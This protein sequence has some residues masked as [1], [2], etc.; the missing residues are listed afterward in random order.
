MECRLFADDLKI[1]CEIPTGNSIQAVSAKQRALDAVRDWSNDWQ[2]KLAI[3]KCMTLHIGNHNPCHQYMFDV[4]PIAI[5]T[6]CRDLGVCV[7]KSFKFHS[8]VDC[9]CAKAYRIVNMLFRCFSSNSV[10]P[11]SCSLQ[12]L[13]KTS[14]GVRLTSMEPLVFD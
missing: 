2:L 7:D 11:L 12:K 6:Q 8:H 14:I 9:V 5:V 10:S 3:Q 13:C 4:V 1:Y